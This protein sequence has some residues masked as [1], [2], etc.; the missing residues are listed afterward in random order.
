MLNAILSRIERSANAV[1]VRVTGNDGRV[2]DETTWSDL[3]SAVM[4]RREQMHAAGVG[5]ESTVVA[6]LPIGADLITT[7]I[8]AW[9]L[10]STILFIGEHEPVLEQQRLCAAGAPTHEALQPGH[11]LGYPPSFRDETDPLTRP[12]VRATVALAWLLCS[13]GTTGPP[14]LVGGGQN[15]SWQAIRRNSAFLHSIGWRPS[16]QTIVSRNLH[17]APLTTFIF[18]LLSGGPVTLAH[19]MDLDTLERTI[20][21]AGPSWALMTPHNM[22]TIMLSDES[23]LER[24]QRSLTICHTAAPCPPSVKRLW[25]RCLGVPAVYEFYGSSEMTGVTVISGSQWLAHP[26]SVGKGIFSRVC[27]LDMDGNTL[28]PGTQGRV[29]FQDRQSR[30]LSATADRGWLDQDGF[31]FLAG[32]ED[33]VVSVGGAKV[34]PSQVERVI[35]EHG[36][37]LDVI[38]RSVPHPSLGGL[39][40]AVVVPAHSNVGPLEADLR[41]HCLQRL[42]KYK[43][44]TKMTFVR[45]LSRSVSGKK[46]ELDDAVSLAE[47]SLSAPTTSGTLGTAD[48]ER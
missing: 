19:R 14:R 6:C 43:V 41:S 26:G 31:L 18:S 37:V 7:A 4:C 11:T 29:H 30:L 42:P 39:L 16:R 3:H 36:G 10:G 32:R 47:P 12:P 27:V 17:A 48:C 35:L 15:L 25:L 23:R 33:D 22:T 8:A 13:G 1:A 46:V 2:C 38:V 21:S 45:N 24:L 9:T 34:S 40:E 5:E 20:A 44:P 28:A